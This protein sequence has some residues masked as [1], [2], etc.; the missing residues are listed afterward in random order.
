MKI[1]LAGA[2]IEYGSLMAE[3]MVEAIRPDDSISGSLWIARELDDWLKTCDA[4]PLVA[5]RGF[6]ENLKNEIKDLDLESVEVPPICSINIVDYLSHFVDINL[7]SGVAVYSPDVNLEVRNPM[8]ADNEAAGV[9]ADRKNGGSSILTRRRGYLHGKQ[10]WVLGGNPEVQVNITRI[11]CNE[12]RFTSET[13]LA[14]E[15]TRFLC[16]ATC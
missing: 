16:I 5:L 10:G 6:A 3:H 2:V 11:A 15:Y 4:S 8:F 13:A 14:A 7:I 1:S 12:L 9:R